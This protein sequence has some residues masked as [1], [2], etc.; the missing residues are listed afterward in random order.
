ME[1]RKNVFYNVLL[2]IS[3]VLFPLITFPYLARTLGP[4]HVG[5]LN[6]AESFAK[7]FVLLAALG[8]PI[9]GVREI[10]KVATD[11][12]QL[13]KTA[14]E[15]FI[16]NALG[17]LLLSV[18]FLVFIFVLPQ[19][20]AEKS[21]FQW[22]LA[23]FI[24]Q[25]FQLEWF[26]S[27]VNQFKFIALRSLVIRLCFIAAVFLF[28]RNTNDYVNYFRMQVGLAVILAALNGKRLWELLDFTSLS[29]KSLE[30]K[31]HLKPM[32]LLFLTIFTISVYFSLDTILLGF[33][34]NNE[35][36]GYYSSAL[37]LNR[38]FIGVLSAIS[39]AMFP[40]LVSLYHKGEKEA[41]VLLVKQC[42]YVLV[43]LAMP[44][45]VGIITCAPEI[46]HILLGT[47]FDRAIL[48]LQITA[49]LILIISMSGIFG[50]QI[51]SA[52]GKDK[53]IL[54]SALIGMFISIV[55]AF[56]FVPSHQEIGAAI[57][58]LV[59]ELAVCTAFVFFTRK[60]IS[61][62][63]YTLVFFQQLLG[64]IPY[65]GIVFL[66]KLFVPTL[67]LRLLVIGVFSLAWF[68]VLQ[69]FILPD[70]IFRAQWNRLADRLHKEE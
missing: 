3:Q 22:A 10:A 49:P 61:L 27:G 48:P 31:K 53:S 30:L 9:Y 41:F 29:L 25:V 38:L 18:I 8:I 17:T 66:F 6:F 57:T 44:L 37:K 26:F 58:I 7:Y 13:T 11:R 51:L 46:I 33:L 63:N 65:I 15:I 56:L 34:A 28:I 32:A 43:S 45:V 40:G 4:E 14:T 24:L 69:L 60:E 59:T 70:T 16:I 42:F 12:V 5:V 1:T 64:L 67:L 55:L 35:S 19:L 2:A 20:A 54:I 23:Y 36:V 47:A 52:V 21:L 68:V 50:F 39:V 62:S